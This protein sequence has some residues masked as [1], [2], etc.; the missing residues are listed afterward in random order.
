MI[1]EGWKRERGGGGGGGAAAAAAAE[2]EAAAGGGGGEEDSG[3]GREGVG[4]VDQGRHEQD[5]SEGFRH[6]PRAVR[7]VD[8]GGGCDTAGPAVTAGG[9]VP[10]VSA[11]KTCGDSA[12]QGEAGDTIRAADVK[13]SRGGVVTQLLSHS[14]DRDQKLGG[15]VSCLRPLEAIRFGWPSRKMVTDGGTEASAEGFTGAQVAVA[16]SRSLLQ[17]NPLLGK[18]CPLR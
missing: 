14:E 6:L 3:S 16:P 1:R 15:Q 5:E 11:C 7:L 10:A 9:S 8:V 2:A 4:A 13:C 17:D 12:A 18:S